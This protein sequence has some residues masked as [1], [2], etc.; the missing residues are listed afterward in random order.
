MASAY[1]ANASAIPIGVETRANV[2]TIFQLA[3]TMVTCAT[4]TGHVNVVN[5][6][7][8]SITLGSTAKNARPVMV[9]STLK[10][11]MSAYCC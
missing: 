8:R 6:Y 3:P 2:E 9:E 1:V 10:C 5:V 7:V 11:Q 4:I